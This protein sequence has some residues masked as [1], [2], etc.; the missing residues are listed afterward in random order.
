M[1]TVTFPALLSRGKKE[2]AAVPARK[3]RDAREAEFILETRFEK[4]R[5]LLPDIPPSA[6]ASTY[7]ETNCVYS[8]S[9]WIAKETAVSRALGRFRQESVLDV[10]CNTGHFSTLAAQSR[11]TVV[12]IDRDP[13]VAGS[14][15][16]SARAG[17]L[18]ILP[19]VVDIARPPGACG[20]ANSECPSFLDR[21]RGRFDCVLMLALMHHLVVNERVPLDR[22]F[23]LAAQLTR[24]L[25]LV[26]YI[27]PGDSQFR[28]IARGRDALH[29]D[30]T[31]GTFEAAARQRFEIVD[32]CVVTRTRVVYTLERKGN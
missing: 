31:P 18:P 7:M 21:A 3:A 20:W 30:L 26:E 10:G 9:E 28:K 14:L 12:A 4:T 19:L 1:S 2:A 16:K 24:R 29:R 5:R 11:A 6:D 25:L 13:G 32:S 23:D 22:I 8:S 27:D 15:W 17:K